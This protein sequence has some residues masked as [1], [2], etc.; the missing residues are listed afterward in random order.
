MRL[1]KI[2]PISYQQLIDFAHTPLMLCRQKNITLSKVGY[3]KHL[4]RLG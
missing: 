2:Q 3:I 1:A 4:E